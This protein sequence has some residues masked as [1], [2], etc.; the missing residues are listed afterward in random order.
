MTPA[1]CRLLLRHYLHGARRRRAT[2]IHVVHNKPGFQPEHGLFHDPDVPVCP[3]PNVS[4][5]DNGRGFAGPAPLRTPG[6]LT[7]R[8]GAVHGPAGEPFPLRHHPVVVF[9]RTDD[10]PTAF[11]VASNAGDTARL[12]PM[13]TAFT[14][15]GT[16]VVFAC[17]LSY[18]Q[19]F[20]L[21]QQECR[22]FPLRVTFESGAAGGFVPPLVDRTPFLEHAFHQVP[23]DGVVV[24]FYAP[25]AA[26]TTHVNLFG[27]PHRAPLPRL[28]DEDG[29]IRAQVRVDVI[30]APG[31]EV[32][33]QSTR[34]L[35]NAC[36]KKLATSFEM[37]LDR[38]TPRSTTN[39]LP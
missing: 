4:V 39:G 11:V 21:L 17:D 28:V 37:L 22:H 36:F 19:V 29:H 25:P 18:R 12:L 35:E 38:A 23:I 26:P 6:G 13:P 27:I 30:D 15:R 5:L 2:W 24:G 3:Y 34:V 31:L 8:D 16:D 32:D 33:P 7:W 9:N 10:P 14:A 20:D 1:D